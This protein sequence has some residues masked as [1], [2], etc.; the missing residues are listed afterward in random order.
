[1]YIREV[2][3]WQ[4]LQGW[5]CV[6]RY[7]QRDTYRPSWFF[8][9]P[10]IVIQDVFFLNIIVWNINWKKIPLKIKFHMRSFS[11]NKVRATKESFALCFCSVLGKIYGLPWWLSDKESSCQCRKHRCDPWVEKIPWRRAWQPTPVFLS[12]K[13]MDR[14]A[15]WA[16]VPEV[17]KSWTRLSS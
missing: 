5:D 12:E 14:G 15:W 8:F 2:S 10:S 13:P 11:P 17:K 4:V 1:M 6:F 9:F 16:A 3:L 7:H